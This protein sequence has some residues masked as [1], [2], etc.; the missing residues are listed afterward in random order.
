[1][2]N[3]TTKTISVFSIIILVIIIVHLVFYLIARQQAVHYIDN[4]YNKMNMKVGWPS[5][6]IFNTI[7]D[8]WY[9]VPV[10]TVNNGMNI[11]FYVDLNMF[12][13]IRDDDL[14]SWALRADAERQ[15]T[16]NVQEIIPSATVSAIDLF[17][18]DEES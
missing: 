10:Y 13:G 8:G 1:M 4:K 15:F 16:K 3:R 11:K 14:L 17:P 5:Q 12:D 7:F 2:K 18:L 9:S 6:S